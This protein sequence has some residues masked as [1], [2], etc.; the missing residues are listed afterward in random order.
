MPLTVRQVSGDEERVDRILIEAD[1]AELELLAP[2]AVVVA[3][4]GSASFVR[5]WYDDELRSRIVA[6]GDGRAVADRAVQ[7]GRRRLGRRRRGDGVR[8]VVPRPR[9][10]IPGRDRPPGVASRSSA[11]SAGSTG[12]SRTSRA[13][14]CGRSCGTSCGRRSRGS[15]GTPP[16]TNPT[17]PARSA[18]SSCSPSP[19]WAPIPRP[20][21]NAA[22]SSSKGRAIRSSCRP[23]WKRWP[24]KEPRR[25]S[26]GTGSGTEAPPRRRR[27]SATCSRRRGS[28]ARPR[29]IAI[30]ASAMSDDVRT[31]DAPYLLARATTNRRQGPKVWRFIADRWDE[32]QDRFA[33][34]NIIGLASG[35]R[36][37]TEPRDRRR[38]RCLLP[39]PRHPA[40]PPDAPAGA[41]ADARGL[42]AARTRD[43]GAARAL[44]QLTA[45]TG[46]PSPGMG[47]RS[48]LR[49]PE[50]THRGRRAVEG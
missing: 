3:N 26:T 36:Y 5:V 38:G 23:P 15:A 41:R 6:R 19:C 7:P 1:G 16:R 30:L 27:R 25:T 40:E 47:H 50:G 37:L 4:A 17:S 2:D 12:S 31:Q 9:A 13:S 22:S 24:P 21:R 42:E 44:R 45:V 35:I 8:R 11:G 34:S 39:R 10:G 32:M 49:R 28:P 46:R 43:P 33:A 20:S 18:G 14:A 48:N 29:S